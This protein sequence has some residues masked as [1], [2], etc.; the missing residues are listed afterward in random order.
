MGGSDD[1]SNLVVLTGREH[2]VA[3]LLLWKIHKTPAM[4]FACNMMAMKRKERGISNIKNSRMYEH[5][6][7]ECAKITGKRHA[8]TCL[9]E[10]NSQYGTRWICN[11]NLKQNKKISKQDDLPNGW[12][13]GRNKW[14]EKNNKIQIYNCIICGCSFFRSRIRKTCSDKCLFNLKNEIK[15]ETR[16]N[17]QIRLK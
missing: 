2:W 6:R 3:H 7:I 16:K 10:G 17:C 1:S 5:I 4:A 15:P 14:I 12:E 8:I 13:F 11:I 9:G